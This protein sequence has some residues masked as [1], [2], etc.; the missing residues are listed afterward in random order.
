MVLVESVVLTLVYVGVLVLPYVV[1]RVVG[2]VSLLV[3]EARERRV[4]FARRVFNP[5]H[6][7]VFGSRG[8][9]LESAGTR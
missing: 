9:A 3:G 2:R 7:P 8:S 5:F 1:A 6:R 4:R